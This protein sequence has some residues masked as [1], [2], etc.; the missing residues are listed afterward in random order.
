MLAGHAMHATVVGVRPSTVPLR[1][2]RQLA[3]AR[4]FLH[5]RPEL[6]RR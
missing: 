2:R 1:E 3:K 6:A 4:R 5:E